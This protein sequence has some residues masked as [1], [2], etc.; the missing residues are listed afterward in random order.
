MAQG[1]RRDEKM[2]SDRGEWDRKRTGSGNTGKIC[3]S[4]LK[5]YV[6]LINS[7][8]KRIYY[9][10]GVYNICHRLQMK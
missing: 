10:L 1:N 4:I 9:K 6:I 5:T 7:A 3:L 8:Y 2:R